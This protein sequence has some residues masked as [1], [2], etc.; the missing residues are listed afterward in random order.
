M[1]KKLT[2]MIAALI[3]SLSVHAQQKGDFSVG[4]SLGFSYGT[5]T[6]TVTE[7]SV[8]TKATMTGPIQLGVSAEAGYFITNHLR[9]TLSAGFSALSEKIMR[10]DNDWL[11]QTTRVVTVGPSLAFYIK[12]ADNLYFTP[13][14]GG[15]YSFGGYSVPSPEIYNS[16]GKYTISQNR[17]DYTIHGFEFAAQLLA[18][19]FKASPRIGIVASFGNIAFADLRGTTEG[20]GRDLKSGAWT[21]DFNTATSVGVRWYL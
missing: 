18:L 19:E 8:D 7:K 1:K 6:S 20:Q 17:Y 14:V 5:S 12:L 2:L 13:E 21:F 11:E 10:I 16:G 15:F 4:G 9:L 3:A